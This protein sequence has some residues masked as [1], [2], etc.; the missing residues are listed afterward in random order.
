MGGN[1]AQR[2]PAEHMTERGR[3]Y[4]ASYLPL[5]TILAARLARGQE[6][7]GPEEKGVYQ[8][9]REQSSQGRI[10]EIVRFWTRE[11]EKPRC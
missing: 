4:L 8:C 9:C 6:V 10:I 2:K 1:Y 11:F 3:S 5:P 7:S